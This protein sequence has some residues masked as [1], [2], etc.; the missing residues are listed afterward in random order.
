M[1]E[2][3][4]FYFKD[5]PFLCYFEGKRRESWNIKIITGVRRCGKSELMK[6][7]IRR[8]KEWNKRN[9]VMRF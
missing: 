8:I 2:I 4:S 9:E 7:Y 1:T 5:I 6:A 3:F